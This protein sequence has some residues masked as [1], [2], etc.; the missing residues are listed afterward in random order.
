[1]PF[2]KGKT[3]LAMIESPQRNWQYADSASLNISWCNKKQ[4]FHKS[5][6][7][8][9]VNP[10]NQAS[11]S[12]KWH[13]QQTHSGPRTQS[14]RCMKSFETDSFMNNQTHKT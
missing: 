10:L 14:E 1:M 9:I 12:N 8:I 6:T 11:S 4:W 3:D 13:L 7:H 2:Y 5:S